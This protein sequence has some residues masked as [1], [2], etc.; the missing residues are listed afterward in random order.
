MTLVEMHIVVARCGLVS[1]YGLGM[2]RFLCLGVRARRFLPLSKVLITPISSR[3][4][5]SF[6]IRKISSN[7]HFQF[8][9][10]GRIVSKPERQCDGE[11]TSEA[12]Q[13]YRLVFTNPLRLL[14]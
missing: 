3:D 6:L 9:Y 10:G 13:G 8:D 4:I 12:I 5:I 1:S 7:L 11:K 2:A 14:Q